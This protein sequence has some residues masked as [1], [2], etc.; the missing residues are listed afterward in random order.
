M[1]QEPLVRKRN[2]GAHLQCVELIGYHIN[3]RCLQ[4]CLPLLDYCAP[5]SAGLGVEGRGAQ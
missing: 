3:S 4:V 1:L 5:F 2:S